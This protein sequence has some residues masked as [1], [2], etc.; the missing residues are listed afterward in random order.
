VAAHRQKA[1]GREDGIEALEEN[2]DRRLASDPRWWERFAEGLDR[3]GVL[4]RV[5][6]PEKAHERQP[7]TDQELGPRPRGCGTSI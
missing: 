6:E 2:L 5:G 4:H 3:L 7:V 1:G